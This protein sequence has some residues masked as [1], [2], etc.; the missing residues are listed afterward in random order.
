ML[1][2]FSSLLVSCT[3]VLFSLLILKFAALA[4]ILD[5]QHAPQVRERYT[6][7]I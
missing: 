2:N 3:V 1:V 7:D 4:L 6:C 5:V